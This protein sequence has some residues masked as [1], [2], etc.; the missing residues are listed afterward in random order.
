MSKFKF[1]TLH[2]PAPGPPIPNEMS[3]VNI[4]VNVVMEWSDRIIADADYDGDGNIIDS[5]IKYKSGFVM[6]VLPNQRIVY[7]NEPRVILGQV[8]LEKK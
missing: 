4:P 1:H 6:V 5:S 8:F 3:I 2:Q 7:Q